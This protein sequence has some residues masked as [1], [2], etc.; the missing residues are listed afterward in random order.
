MVIY[1]ESEAS[2][3]SYRPY[4][5][6]RKWRDSRRK[7]EQSGQGIHNGQGEADSDK[8]KRAVRQVFRRTLSA[9]SFEMEH[10]LIEDLL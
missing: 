10:G 8:E 5:R 4:S 9:L 3:F 2:Y 1:Y 6:I 7:H